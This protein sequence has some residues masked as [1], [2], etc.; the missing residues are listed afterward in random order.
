MSTRDRYRIGKEELAAMIFAPVYLGFGI[1][2]AEPT[3]GVATFSLLVG[4]IIIGRL[5]IEWPLAIAIRTVHIV[6]VAVVALA[7]MSII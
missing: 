4:T 6:F 2:F 5:G 3:L 1:L 7:K